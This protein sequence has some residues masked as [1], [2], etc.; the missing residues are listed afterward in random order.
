VVWNPFLLKDI[1]AIEKVQRRF[2]KLTY[3][4]RLVKVGLES[5]ELRRI[6]VDLVFAYKIIFGLTDVNT[7]DIF[8]VCAS[9]SRRGHGYKMYMPY[10]KFTA[11]YNYFNH[12]VGRIWNALPCDEVD[13]SSLRRFRNS[14][15]A[16]V[17]VRYCSLKFI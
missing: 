12:T 3:H 11:R 7:E 10:S 14:L 5:L 16:K 9:N 6:R 4:Q 1:T 2:T 8:T 17:S 13:F 15:T